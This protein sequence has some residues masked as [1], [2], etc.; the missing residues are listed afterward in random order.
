[1]EKRN[2]LIKE[3]KVKHPHTHT[4][5]HRKEMLKVSLHFHTGGI[6]FLILLFHNTAKDLIGIDGSARQR[7]CLYFLWKVPRWLLVLATREK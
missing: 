1:M 5:S 4:D 2:L 7:L 3:T 6:G